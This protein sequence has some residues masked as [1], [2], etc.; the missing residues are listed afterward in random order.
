MKQNSRTAESLAMGLRKAQ[1]DM[2]H[3]GLDVRLRNLLL[4]AKEEQRLH[5]TII[6]SPSV[7][8]VD[9]GGDDDDDDHRDDDHL[10][11]RFAARWEF[12]RDPREERIDQK[13]IWRRKLTLRWSFT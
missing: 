4:V 9:H 5:E 11:Q 8:P 7:D 12:L 1:S 10:I 13:R 2:S 3:T 6:E